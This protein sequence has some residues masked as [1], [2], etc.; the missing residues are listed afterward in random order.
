MENKI[1][2]NN[3]MDLVDLLKYCWSFFVRFIVNPFLFLFKFGLKN[4]WKLAISG[5]VGV[6]LSIAFSKIDYFSVYKASLTLQNNVAKSSDFVNAVNELSTS[7]AIT[8]SSA[9]GLKPSQL[10]NIRG[11]KGHYFLPFDSLSS[12]D[13][14]DKEDKYLVLSNEQGLL[15]VSPIG[16]K[17]S[18]ELQLT[19]VSLLPQIEKSL[20]HYFDNMSYFKQEND[21]RLNNLKLDMNASSIELTAVD[22]LKNIEYFENSRRQ[23]L[24]PTEG[25]AVMTRA[26][27]MLHNDV[28]YLRKQ[29]RIK[30][31]ELNYLPNVLTVV[32]DFKSE[33]L[34]KNHWTVTLV[35]FVLVTV[36]FTYFILLILFYRKKIESFAVSK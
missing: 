5:C 24:S 34:P 12:A 20:L 17:F 10:I 31:S 9:L 35:N 18:I 21:R 22:S 11:I 36:L 23:L 4:W 14:V 19:D 6:M 16:H 13:Y 15:D 3:E 27:P 33:N 8:L 30:E 25:G 2:D 28:L 7:D 26:I 32:S 1:T 29:V